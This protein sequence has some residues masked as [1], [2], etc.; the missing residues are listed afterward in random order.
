MSDI[1]QALHQHISLLVRIGFDSRDDIIAEAVDLFRDDYDKSELEYHAPKITDDLIAAHYAIQQHWTHETDCDKLDEAFAELDRKGIVARQNWTCCQ[2]CG[3]AEMGY[4]IDDVRES[5]T[6]DAVRGYVFYHQQ[7]S[8]S[9][10][11]SD[12]LYLAYGTP[13]GDEAAAAAIAHE[14]VAV[15]RDHKL[16]VE[17]NGRIEKRICIKEFHWERRYLL[18]SLKEME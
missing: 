11:E 16:I 1:Q 18:P 10:V 13:N 3:H 4:E 5:R 14:V 8:E 15:L 12:K 17:W 9:C 7:D 6:P 2:T